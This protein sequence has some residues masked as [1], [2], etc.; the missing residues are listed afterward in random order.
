M[1]HG[2]NSD[3]NFAISGV[4]ILHGATFFLTACLLDKAAFDH[5]KDAYLEI[6]PHPSCALHQGLDA[7]PEFQGDSVAFTELVDDV[8]GVHCF[9]GLG[10]GVC[11]KPTRLNIP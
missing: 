3:E 6:W 2:G 7:A 9:W 10:K 11:K 5:L 8:E 1:E 4:E